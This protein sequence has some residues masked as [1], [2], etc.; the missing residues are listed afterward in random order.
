MIDRSRFFTRR[1]L[2]WY[3]AC[4][5]DLPWRR[6]S[7]P[8]A[9]W[10][11]EIM[12][13]QTQ[14]ATVLPYYHRFLSAFPTVQDLADAPFE[15][16]LKCWEGLGYYARARHLHLASKDIVKRFD[17]EIPSA[18]NDILSLPGIGRSTAGAIL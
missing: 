7:D 18:Y 8:Y 2:R 10:I 5:R 13:Q 16:V 17:G 15:K 14:V 9:I 11:S 1:L 6:T 12:L 3:R 4:G